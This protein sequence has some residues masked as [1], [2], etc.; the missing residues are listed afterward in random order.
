[1]IAGHEQQ[2]SLWP[3]QQQLELEQ[4]Q[5][6]VVGGKRRRYLPSSVR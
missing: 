4:Q 1:M 5:L 2:M 3:K 6:D